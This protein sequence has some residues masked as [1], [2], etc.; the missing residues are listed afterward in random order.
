MVYNNP[1]F[2][3]T[4]IINC[5]GTLVDLAQPRIMGI[6]NITPDSF[7][8]RSRF[9]TTDE[10]L[11]QTEKML[12]AGA[13]FLDLGGH[14]TRPGASP[15]SQDEEMRRVVPAVEQILAR[16]P[17][18]LISIDT[19][20]ASVA[21]A[22]VEAGAVMINDV[23]GGLLDTQMYKTVAS[24]G[25]VPYVLM[26]MRGTIETMMQMTQYD[27][28]VLDILD[29][30]QQKVAQ[31]RALNQ[32]DIILDLGFGFAKNIEQNYELLNH[33][34]DFAVMNLPMLV[35]V[36]RKSMIWRKLNIPASEA[37]NGTTAL[38]TVAL[39]K[40]AN[41]LRVHDVK[42]AIEVVQLVEAL[43]VK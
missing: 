40:G 31:L 25:N 35:G 38:N 1:D 29:D 34:E 30:L 32:R 4:Q 39:L 28:L 11:T 24:F 9:Y 43:L 14:S 3:M 22:C 23:S 33:I 8:E 27:N 7:F 2:G 13:T 12:L 15:V 37:L 26:H 36:S 16:F 10:I 20:R 19:F 6:M 42:E 18:A 21:K 5:R 17:E 41:I